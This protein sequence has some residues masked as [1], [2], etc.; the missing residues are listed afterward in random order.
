MVSVSPTFTGWLA[1]SFLSRLMRTRPET[2]SFCASVRLLAMRANHSHLS[3]RWRVSGGWPVIAGLSRRAP[4]PRVRPSA[5]RGRRTENSG[6][7]GLLR[8]SPFGG[9]VEKRIGSAERGSRRGR[10][11]RSRRGPSL[12]SR[13]GHPSPSRR[14]PVVARAFAVFAVAMAWPFVPLAA[15][16][17]DFGS[18]ACVGRR[19]DGALLLSPAGWTGGGCRALRPAMARRLL[20][21]HVAP[22][23]AIS[24][25]TPVRLRLLARP[26]VPR[27]SLGCPARPR[28]HQAPAPQL[29]R[30]HFPVARQPR[31]PRWPECSSPTAS[32][33][34]GASM[35]GSSQSWLRSAASFFAGAGFRSMR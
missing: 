17:P 34:A 7:A 8:L 1:L 2:A 12:P 3:M 6:S 27:R 14:G 26:Q 13:G 19:R 20:A 28:W 10:S 25:R 21:D 9:S 31:P 35:V 30:P 33:S 24:R 5:R 11:D 23:V 22:P 29:R 32:A 4:W 16:R 15:R 18:T